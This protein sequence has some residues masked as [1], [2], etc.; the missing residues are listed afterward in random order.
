MRFA[1]QNVPET[2]HLK[3]LSHLFYTNSF[4]CFAGSIYTDVCEL[5]DK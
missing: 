5:I 3:I 4:L 1:Y 2:K